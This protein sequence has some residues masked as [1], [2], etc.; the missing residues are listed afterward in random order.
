MLDDTYKL[1]ILKELLQMFQI[2]RKMPEIMTHPNVLI[3]LELGACFIIF[4]SPY[5]LTIWEP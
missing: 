1:L 2:A 5:R 4:R 3:L